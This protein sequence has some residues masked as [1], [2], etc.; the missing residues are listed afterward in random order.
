[1]PERLSVGIQKSLSQVQRIGCGADTPIAPGLAIEFR[2]QFRPEGWV[3]VNPE[4]GSLEAGA[5]TN[6]TLTYLWQAQPQGS[7]LRTTIVISSS[8]PRRRTATVMTEAV[9]LPAP[10]VMW[11]SFVA[12]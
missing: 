3:I 2:P 10:H 1:L 4:K 9:M 6:L 12:R 8:D 5:S 7:R 11:L